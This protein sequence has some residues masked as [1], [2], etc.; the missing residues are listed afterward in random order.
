MIPEFKDGK[1]IL[2][3]G[4]KRWD[5]REKARQE[6]GCVCISYGDIQTSIETNGKSAL[7]EPLDDIS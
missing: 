4:T 3:R 7:W 1:D 2:I 5:E 6:D